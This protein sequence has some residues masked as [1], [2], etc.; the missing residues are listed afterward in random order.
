[1]DELRGCEGGGHRREFVDYDV[2]GRIAAHDSQQGN[3]AD[4]IRLC[5][6]MSALGNQIHDVAVAVRV[7]RKMT[8]GTGPA[9][10]ELPWCAGACRPH[11]HH[12]VG[13]WA[14]CAYHLTLDFRCQRR[15]ARQ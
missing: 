15:H 11:G 10:S 12:R 1:M 2:A 8:I 4:L 13:D 6:S 3:A 9:L 7:Q 14:C 5:G